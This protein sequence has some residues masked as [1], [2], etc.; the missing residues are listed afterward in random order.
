M[1]VTR[2]APRIEAARPNKKGDQAAEAGEDQV[3]GAAQSRAAGRNVA[4]QFCQ[5]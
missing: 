1:T 2:L 5:M 3:Y 4:H